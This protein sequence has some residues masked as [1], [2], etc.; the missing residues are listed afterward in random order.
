LHHRAREHRFPV[1][2]HALAHQQCEFERLVVDQR[3]PALRRNQLNDLLEVICRVSGGEHE[4][5]RADAQR[6][7]LL[8]NRFAMVDDVMSS[9]IL[10]PAPRL[11]AR[12]SPPR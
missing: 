11:R 5:G 2:R 6:R 10:D 8:G 7:N 9:E 1:D 4:P 12:Q 3:E